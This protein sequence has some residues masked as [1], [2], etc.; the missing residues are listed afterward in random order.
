MFKDIS[1]REIL[2]LLADLRA[3][4]MQLQELRGVSESQCGLWGH[5]WQRESYRVLSS[6]FPL[7]T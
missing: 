4:W 2:K 3:G 7:G 6:E 5:A 1:G